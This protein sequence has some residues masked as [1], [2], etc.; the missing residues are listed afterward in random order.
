MSIRVTIHCQVLLRDPK[1]DSEIFIEIDFDPRLAASL[2]AVWRRD[3]DWGEGHEWPGMVWLGDTDTVC[4]INV[5]ACYEQTGNCPERSGHW[6][7]PGSHWPPTIWWPGPAISDHLCFSL[8]PSHYPDINISLGPS[9]VITS[10]SGDGDKRGKQSEITHWMG[11]VYYFIWF[12]LDPWWQRSHDST[13]SRAA[14][15]PSTLTHN[16]N[17]TIKSEANWKV[18]SHP[19]VLSNS[20]FPLVGE[21]NWGPVTLSQLSATGA[22]FVPLYCGWPSL[23]SWVSSVHNR[24]GNF[25]WCLAFIF[26]MQALRQSRQ[27]P[28]P[29]QD[30]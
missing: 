21:G 17:I 28:E 25:L 4:Q 1:S 29:V 20:Y 14:S 10:G 11:R 18:E 13:P 15:K 2:A 19:G 3:I 5:S 6:P 26:H 12:H 22:V 24:P 27:Q 7:P 8:V 30:Q 23:P 16:H 9:T